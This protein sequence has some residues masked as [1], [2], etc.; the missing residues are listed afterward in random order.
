MAVQKI[1]GV[2][3][4]C[5]GKYDE[6]IIGG[7][8]TGNGDIEATSIVLDG[9]V[10]IT[11]KIVSKEFVRVGGVVTINGNIRAKEATIGGVCTANGSIEADYVSC[12]GV[13]S[14][15]SQ[16]SADLVE[17]GGVLSA[18]EIVGEKVILHCEAKKRHLFGF[19]RRDKQLSEIKLIE[20]TEID[21]D[22]IKCRNLNGQNIVIGPECI[23][24]NV[25]CSGS[26]TIAPEAQVKR[27]NG[28]PRTE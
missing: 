18:E 4:F 6:L 9:V 21:V 7:V 23:I 12:K 15:S 22:G 17:G 1:G 25:E 5:G 20:A 2:S 8:V 26:L 28:Q 27:V 10:T 19:G 24:E 14:C 3:N 16:I 11:G 13:F